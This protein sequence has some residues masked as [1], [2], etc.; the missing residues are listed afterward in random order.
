MAGLLDRVRY[1]LTG[2][3]P[4][5]RPGHLQPLA[6]IDA[7]D[8]SPENQKHWSRADAC[9]A[10]AAYD[11]LTRQR[12]RNRSRY[13]VL[14]NCYAKSSVRQ[15]ANDLI[16]TGPRLQLL[17]PDSG[18]AKLIERNWHRW[19]KA[20]YLVSN[21]RTAQKSLDRDGES[22]GIFDSDLNLRNPVKFDI[23]WVE[24]ELCTDSWN[25]AA[26]SDPLRIDGIRFDRMG[27]PIEYQ[28]LRVHPGGL[29]G[30]GFSPLET[31]PI[32][33]ERVIHWY[34]RDRFGQHRGIPEITPALPLYSQI[35]R[36]TLATLT[37]AEFAAMLAGVMTTNQA[38]DDGNAT[39][40]EDWTLWEMVR[41][42]L[43]SLPEGWDAKQFE[44]KQPTT[45]Y[46]DF[47]REV[48]NESGRATGQPLN[49]VTGNSSGYNFSSGRLDFIPYHRDLRIERCDLELMVLDR[50]FRDGW[51]PEALAVGQVPADAPPIEEWDWSWNWPGFAGIDENKDANADDTRIKNGTATY[52]EIY[53]EYGENWEE[54]FEQLAR[55]K[56]KAEALGLPWPV[57]YDTPP[58]SG[59]EPAP[60]RTPQESV[61]ALL[62]ESD[63]SEESAREVMDALQPVFSALNVARHRN[64]NGHA[65]HVRV[66][67]PQPVRTTLSVKRGKDG[68]ITETV[69]EH[70]YGDD[71]AS[72]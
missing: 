35:R 39:K 11:N 55:E 3:L 69:E 14:N 59:S 52:S 12:L 30:L 45:G 65:P 15:K 24:A 18:Q 36:F 5:A 6:R 57:L 68:L 49:V 40:M 10:D 2:R 48:L 46:A 62:E 64:G 43:L 70:D 63:L 17:L 61:A 16:G 50:I 34:N 19:C 54:K 37:A 13:E 44:A 41:G 7:A 26:F 9:S 33:A 31:M 60:N 23:R 53:A 71:P 25:A 38:P 28:F 1:L 67:V 56:A 58:G 21:L 8:T 66:T 32:S 42:A 22:F 20:T 4:S 27:K 51:Y 47:K 72:E 29:T